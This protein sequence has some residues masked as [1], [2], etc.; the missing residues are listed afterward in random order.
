M[1]HEIQNVDWVAK[2]NLETNIEIIFDNQCQYLIL[3]A[4]HYPNFNEYSR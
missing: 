1:F 4:S 3:L 2:H